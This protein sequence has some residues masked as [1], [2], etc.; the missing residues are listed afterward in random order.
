MSG[1]AA[2]LNCYSHRCLDNN[3]NL[4]RARQQTRRSVLL[5]FGLTVIRNFGVEDWLSHFARILPTFDKLDKAISASSWPPSIEAVEGE[6][7]CIKHISYDL[8]RDHGRKCCT[9]LHL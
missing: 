3:A 6:Q 8:Y 2:E 5:C 9:T 1:K 4:P 7:T